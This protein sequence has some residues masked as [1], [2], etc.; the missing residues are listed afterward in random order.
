MRAPR[1]AG[2]GT[3]VAIALPLVLA[4][5]TV[6]AVVLTPTRPVPVVA[7]V[8]FTALGLGYGL[9]PIAIGPMSSV[10]MGAPTILL[11][12]LTGGPL[13]A[14][15]AAVAQNIVDPIWRRRL[16]YAGRDGLAAL[17]AGIAGNLWY[18]GTWTLTTALPVA[19]I[20][21]LSVSVVTRLLIL[22]DRQQF[23]PSLLTRALRLEG[24]ELTIAAPLVW[25]TA[26]TGPTRAAIAATSLYAMLSLSRRVH[27]RTTAALHTERRGAETDPLTGLLNTGAFTT[28]LQRHHAAL[29]SGGCCGV[30][31]LDL[32]HFKRVNDTYGHLAGNDV[33]CEVARRLTQHLR[34]GDRAARFGGEEFAVLTPDTTSERLT[35]L[36]ERLRTVIGRTPIATC[37]GEIALTTSVG[38]T[39]MVPQTPPDATLDHA[40]K[41][42]YLAKT[43]RNATNILP[44]S[45]AN[46]AIHRRMRPSV[47]RFRARR[48]G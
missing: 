26:S 1:S 2:R 43:T 33:L 17:A 48:Q 8:V 3:V 25:V 16:A 4:A 21:A 31:L 38:G 9:A 22:L 44:A 27:Q 32:D 19:V 24:A 6:G 42:L 46:G 28:L 10:I 18:A 35:V 29:S 30:L 39:L 34:P 14:V 37:A 45:S 36:A 13:V 12:G 40:D 23:H 5:A 11:A 20:G 41:A 15:L 47:D 7:L